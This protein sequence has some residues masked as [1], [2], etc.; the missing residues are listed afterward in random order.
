MGK[1]C[2]KLKFCLNLDSAPNTSQYIYAIMPPQKFP[3]QTLPVSYFFNNIP[4]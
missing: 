3:N 2:M 4:T 1:V